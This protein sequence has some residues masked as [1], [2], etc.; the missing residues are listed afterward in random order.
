MEGALVTIRKASKNPVAGV[1][2]FFVTDPNSESG[3]EHV[4]VEIKRDGKTYHCDCS[5]FMFRKL[6]FLGTNLFSLCKHGLAV[7]E[8]LEGKHAG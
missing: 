1:R 3:E 4:V 8:A 5:D 6:P 2:T 7:R